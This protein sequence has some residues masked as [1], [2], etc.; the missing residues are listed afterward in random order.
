[1][2]TRV[3]NCYDATTKK[4]YHRE[5]NTVGDLEVE[6]IF[7]EFQDFVDCLEN[8]LSGID[9]TTFDFEGIDLTKYDLSKA[10]VSS[11]T[12]KKFGMYD[13]SFYRKNIISFSD[14]HAYSNENETL[15]SEY[16][17]ND[18]I[19]GGL[20][21][22]RGYNKIFYITD[23]HIDFKIR[24]IFK[25]AGTKN[26]I[27]QY[28]SSV[29]EILKK[30]FE[31]SY[32]TEKLLLIGGD[33]SESFEICEMF[34]EELVKR[35]HYR[36][37]VV[38]LGNHELW[39]YAHS[40]SVPR[41]SRLNSIIKDY[42]SLF[43][44]LCISFLQ[45]MLFVYKD[46]RRQFVR[47]EE[48]LS[49]S[50]KEI[51]DFCIDSPLTILGGIGFSGYCEKYNY[52]SGIYRDALLSRSEDIAETEKFEAVYNKVLKAVADLPVIVFT[53]MPTDNWSRNEYNPAWIYVSGHTHRNE[54]T[55]SE[56]VQVYNDN[57]IGY[58]NKYIR[59]KSFST[60]RS[61]DIFKDYK[62]GIY[63]INEANYHNF[64]HGLCIKM[65]C[66]RSGTYHMVKRSGYYCFLLEG[67]D[68]RM[69]FLEGGNI[70]R[71]PTSDLEYYFENMEIYSKK[72]DV[73]FSKYNRSLKKIS[74]LVKKF[75]GSGKIHGCI[76]DIDFFNHVYVNPLDGTITPYHA[77]DMV[78]KT[79]YNNVPSLLYAHCEEMYNQYVALGDPKDEVALV[80]AGSGKISKKTKKYCG[81]DI[82]SMS[83]FFLKFQ[84]ATNSRVIR[85][86]N[87]ELLHAQNLENG[88]ELMKILAGLSENEL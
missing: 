81:T 31:A 22:Q 88:V 70:R 17:E 71:A 15:P 64:Y 54:K 58:H 3:I 29:V 79:V 7:D 41:E 57:Q 20:E 59:L 26:E 36:D 24:D 10:I 4:F 80:L 34:Y 8:D 21:P 11:Q 52:D 6:K 27:R 28:I 32:H 55:F 66:N 60:S 39:D 75:G 76:V 5:F 67:A 23:L 50:D 49:A 25:E 19:Q 42:E 30:D 65:N 1:M 51:R 72:I 63:E 68:G 78:D 47:G 46:N 37:I 40:G 85:T 83:K 33:V 53:H 48:L 82:Y 18:L 84:Y 16:R 2:A 44:R 87:E 38:I 74:D 45:N 35:I 77:E 73:F 43:D 56:Y 9:L 86:W 61:Y 14:G 13:D 69:Y 12:L 62:D